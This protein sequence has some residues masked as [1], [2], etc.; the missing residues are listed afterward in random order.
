MDDRTLFS[1]SGLRGIVGE[2]LTIPLV[3]KYTSAFARHNGGKLYFVGQDTRPH[4]VAIKLAVISTLLSLGKEVVDFGVV[5]T[6]T[7]LLAIRER[8]AD[9]GVMITASHNPIEWNALKFANKNGLFISGEDVVKVEELSQEE[10]PW[11]RFNEF[12]PLRQNVNAIKDHIEKILESPFINVSLIRKRKFK[13]VCD[14]INGAAYSAIPALLAELGA[15]V[16]CINCDDSGEFTRNPEPKKEHLMELEEL[17]FEKDADIAFATDPDGDRLL[18][19]F[20]DIGLISEEYTVPLS[21]Y[22]IL[23]KKK[24]DVV[25]NLSTSMMIEHVA[26]KFKVNVFRTAV[27]EANVV[28][29]M[30]EKDAVIGGEG[31]GGVIFPAINA[32]RD[33]LTG[34]AIILSLIAEEDIYSIYS[35][36][37]RFYM[38]KK[39]MKY[40]SELPVEKLEKAFKGFKVDLTDGVYLRKKDAWIHIRKSNTEP[41]VRIYAESP[42]EEETLS[43]IARAEEVLSN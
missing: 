4:S 27:G 20:R 43:L 29:M 19:G 16:F 2:S 7:L 39:Q 26:E 28:K 6:P 9:G 38:R 18:V 34:I 11:S 31:N 33:S 13:V 5:P 25:V 3:V 12:K 32:C 40:Y 17:L 42:S 23:S 8:K 35:S 22:Y 36:I 15:E 1:V 30:I 41:I 14:C 24:G 10:P 21:A 37:P